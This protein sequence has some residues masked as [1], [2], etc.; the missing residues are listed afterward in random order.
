MG[1]ESASADPGDWARPR[2]CAYPLNTLAGRFHAT[3]GAPLGALGVRFATS[4]FGGWV[5]QNKFHTGRGVN[6]FRG[7]RSVSFRAAVARCRLSSLARRR[8]T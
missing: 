1:E 7:V 8:T 2:V 4:L 6:A 3:L 5:E